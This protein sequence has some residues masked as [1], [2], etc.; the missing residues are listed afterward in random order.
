MMVRRVDPATSGLSTPRNGAL[1]VHKIGFTS[2]SSRVAHPPMCGLSLGVGPPAKLLCRRPPTVWQSAKLHLT[3]AFRTRAQSA[4]VRHVILA[5][6]S[7]H[8]CVAHV[9]ALVGAR[10]VASAKGH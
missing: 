2:E 3:Y 6:Y 10:S 1:R 7:K 8:W 5:G 4:S 9:R